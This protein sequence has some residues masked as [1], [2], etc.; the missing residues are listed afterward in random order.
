MF[1]GIVEEV[2][3]VARN[4]SSTYGLKLVIRANDI[5]SQVPVGGSIAVEGVCLTITAKTSEGFIADV[6]P[7]TAAHTTLSLLQPGTFVN[8]ERA[9]SATGRFDGH[10]VTGHVDCTGEITTITENGNAHL[11]QINIPATFS[12]YLVPQ[13]SIALDGISLTI[14]DILPRA[15]LTSIIPHTW[16][17]TSICHKHPGSRVNLEYD[18]IAK[19]VYHYLSQHAEQDNLLTSPAPGLSQALLKEHGFI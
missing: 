16:S 19:H 3:Q 5:I 14:V 18:I 6:M 9:M 10:M 4:Q 15:F 2:G 17:H 7:V 12:R 8:L 11:I 1:T 13:G